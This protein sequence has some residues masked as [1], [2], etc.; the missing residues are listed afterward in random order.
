MLKL[1]DDNFFKK[2]PLNKSQTRLLKMSLGLISYVITLSTL[3]IF[4]EPTATKEDTV[5]NIIKAFYWVTTTLTTIG[6]GDIVPT[7]NFARIFTIFVEVSGVAIYSVV[8]AQVARVFV[9]IDKKEEAISTKI[10][11]LT[12]LLR[13]Y[14]VPL[15]LQKEAIHCYSHLLDT[16]VQNSEEGV[17]NELPPSL[18]HEIR[19]H[20]LTKPLAKIPL[21]AH[22][23]SECLKDVALHL[24]EKQFAPGQTIFQQNDLASEMYIVGNGEV[25]IIRDGQALAQLK[26]GACFGESSLL[27][28]KPRS[29]S[30][31]SRSYTTLYSL[32][33]VQFHDLLA[34]H[35]DLRQQLER[36]HQARNDDLKSN[37]AA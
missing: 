32:S 10:E 1:L 8:F 12:S 30:A 13:H 23:R 33:S 36:I 20:M 18:A 15:K 31:V 17:L 37:V 9:A 11:D 28:D 21:F 29:A 19:L 25:S 35:Q 2:L 27:E 6:F 14:N 24:V 34:K 7:S 26:N 22:C 16:R 3:W 5:T 4:I